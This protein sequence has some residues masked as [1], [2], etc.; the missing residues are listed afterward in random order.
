MTD[1]SGL[2]PHSKDWP[3]YWEQRRE[4]LLSGEAQ[5]GTG[6]IPLEAVYALLAVWQAEAKTDEDN[7]RESLSAVGR[8]EARLM[9]SSD[10]W[11][12]NVRI[13]SSADGSIIQSI[14]GNI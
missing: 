5:G 8:I 4:R 2:V 6:R 3:E 9:P 1:I 13:I 7:H 12:I 10:P 11:V 14:L